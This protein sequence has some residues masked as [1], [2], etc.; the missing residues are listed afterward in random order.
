VDKE[1]ISDEVTYEGSVKERIMNVSYLPI[2]KFHLFN[3]LSALLNSINTSFTFGNASLLHP[4]LK[5]EA[6][7]P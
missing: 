7:I 4:S 3:I 1:D 2:N 6:L 5:N